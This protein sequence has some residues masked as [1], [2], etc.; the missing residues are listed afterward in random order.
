MITCGKSNYAEA[1]LH[2]S[3]KDSTGHETPHPLCHDNIDQPLDLLTARR[4]VTPP[5]RTCTETLSDIMIIGYAA[6]GQHDGRSS[7]ATSELA[8]HKTLRALIAQQ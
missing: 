1:A 8:S 7:D 2:Y 3:F 5:G 4:P 6:H